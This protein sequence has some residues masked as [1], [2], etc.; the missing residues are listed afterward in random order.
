MVAG[1]GVDV[2]GLAQAVFD[3]VVAHYAASTVE[4]PDR[5]IIAPGDIRAVAWDCPSLIVAFSGLRW[6]GGPGTNSATALPTG[7]PLSMGLRHA[8][9]TVQIVRAIS[10]NEDTPAAAAVVTA[11]GLA[12]VRDAGLLS[13]ALV[14]LV[15]GGVMRR[16]GTAIAGDVDP[17]GP[18]GGIAGVEGTLTVTAA[19]VVDL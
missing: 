5:R 8:V 11:E 1:Q 7:R 6:G 18:L 12:L 19:S 4:L 14:D 16:A 9:I 10:D 3:A 13:Q 17:L 15:G 2:A